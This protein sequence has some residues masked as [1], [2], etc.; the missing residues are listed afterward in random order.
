MSDLISR[1]AV[2][3]LIDKE[4]KKSR[5]FLQHDTQINIR[6]LIEELPTVEPERGE[7]I[8]CSERLPDDEDYVLVC[9]TESEEGVFIA[10]YVEGANEWRYESD[11]GMYHIVHVAAWQPLPE[12]FDMRKKVG[13]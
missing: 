6:F 11:E 12:P 3:K 9:A 8:P 10:H 13:E 1:S 2:I 7:W 4:I 5:D